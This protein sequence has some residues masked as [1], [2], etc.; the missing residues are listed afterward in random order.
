M[1]SKFPEVIEALDEK[2]QELMGMEPLVARNVQADTPVGGVYLF[3]ED[4]VHMYAGRT[5]QM[6]GVRIKDHFGTA[7]DCPFAWLLARE[8]TGKRATYTQS[9]SRKTLLA[10]QIFR[11]TYD[12]AKHRI[13]E[14]HV[15][16]VHEADPL[17]QVLLEIY[18]AVASSAKYND[19]DTH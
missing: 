10:D 19:F 8:A 17:R 15:R 14:M 13:R 12:N 11:A 5:K 6:I 2:W 9:G 18:V 3:S 1:N 16:Y 7:L 4:G